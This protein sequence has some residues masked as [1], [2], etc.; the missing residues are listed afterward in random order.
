[1]A[2]L[3]AQAQYFTAVQQACRQARQS[4]DKIDLEKAGALL[5]SDRF[6]ELPAEAQVD[7]AAAFAAAMVATTGVFS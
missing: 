4:R 6:D 3:D 5:E 2:T 7:L 1:M